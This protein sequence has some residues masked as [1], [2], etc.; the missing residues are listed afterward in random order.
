MKKIGIFCL[1]ARRENFILA[2]AHELSKCKYDNFHFYILSNG[3]DSSLTNKIKLYLGDKVSIYVFD[4][5]HMLNYMMKVVFALNQNHEYSIKHDEDCFMTTDSWDQF[6]SNIENLKD[7]DLLTT[8]AIST[9]IPTVE[10]F[11]QHHGEKIKNELYSMF[12]ETKL[13]DH[14][15]D[16]RSLNENLP[17]WDPDRFYFKVKNFNHYYKG[18]HPVRVRFDC[19][20]KINDYILDNFESVMKPK[21]TNIIKDNSKYPYFCNNIFGIKTQN[22]KN[23]VSDNSLFVDNF[24][25]VAI[26]KYRERHNMNF[27]FDVGIPIIHTMYNWSPEFEYEKN[28]IEKIINKTIL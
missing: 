14:G 8:G 10:F 15:A 11:L 3:M 12:N 25:E 27:V 21:E 18:I 6:F 24:D 13:T 22:W 28:L 20:K 16:Y 4:R 5:N 17:E 7:D 19:Q 26:N 9:G 23:I 2:H 1:G